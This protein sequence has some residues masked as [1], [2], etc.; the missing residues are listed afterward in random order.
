MSNVALI[1]GASAGLGTEFARYHASKGGDVI[2]TARREETLNALKSELEEKHNI[3]AHVIA[4]D[5]GA[6]GGAQKLCEAVD[7]LGLEIKVLVNNAGF[8]GLGLHIDR[9]LDDELAMIDL[10]VKALV[11]LAHHYGN[12]MVKTGG[13]K[14]LNVGS[15]AGFIPGPKQAIYFATKAFVKSFSFA[16]DHELRS[17]G[18]T[19]TLLAPGYVETEFVDHAN[20]HGINLVK[21]GGAKASDVAKLGYDAMMAGKLLTIN[22]FG[23][24]FLLQWIVPFIPYRMV[25]KMTA[26]T[27][28]KA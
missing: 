10:N 26:R 1:T 25:L 19:C 15:T 21:D 27:Q 11:H 18:V 2:I 17:K 4:L 8:G 20:M 5:L 14:I 16:I 13:G 6:P 28:S 22:E 3:K 9:P 12:Q 7:A 23:L 24:S